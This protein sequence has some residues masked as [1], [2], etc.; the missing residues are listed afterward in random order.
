MSLQKTLVLALC[1]VL[2]AVVVAARDFP[3][4]WERPWYCHD[5]DCPK[6]KVLNTTDQY[7]VRVYESGQWVSTHVESYL[8]AAA[9]TQG[10]QRLFKYISGANQANEKI[11][12]TAPVATLIE[13]GDGPFCKSNFTV[14]FFVPYS[15]QGKAPQPTNPDVYLQTVPSA[16]MYVLQSG[17]FV[18]DDTSLAHKAADLSETLKGEGVAVNEDMFFS[19][20]YD[21]PF[22]LQHRHNEVW[23][24]GKDEGLALPSA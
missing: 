21:P 6:F 16:T 10:F 17:G 3:A 9:V 19:A 14:S 22:R 13:P 23:V 5:L 4:A 15:L 20:S 7:E 24:I 8:Y 1:L 2:S 12:M 11:A 18:V